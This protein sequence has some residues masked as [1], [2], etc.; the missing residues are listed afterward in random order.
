[1]LENIFKKLSKNY[2]KHNIFSLS[3]WNTIIFSWRIPL[4]EG[5]QT[6]SQR[7]DWLLSTALLRR[8]NINALHCSITNQYFTIITHFSTHFSTL[9]V[10]NST[11]TTPLS[12]LHYHHSLLNYHYLLI[13]YHYSLLH[14]RYSLVD[15]HNLL[16]NFQY[17]IA[18]HFSTITVH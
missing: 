1:M 2:L 8:E 3:R 7:A 18:T 12:P 5:R 11:I 16:I 15:Y 6:D 17:A 4:I 13:K 10:D 14:Y 9:T